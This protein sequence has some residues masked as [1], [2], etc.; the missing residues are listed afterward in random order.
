[1]WGWRCSSASNCP[2]K[3]DVSTLSPRL[4]KPIVPGQHRKEDLIADRSETSLRSEDTPLLM[5]RAKKEMLRHAPN[6]KNDYAVALKRADRLFAP[7][8]D[9]REKVFISCAP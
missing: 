2:T 3:N 6:L 9:V 4:I 8:D 1:M 7:C 5:S